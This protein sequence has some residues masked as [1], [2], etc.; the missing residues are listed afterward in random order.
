M[1]QIIENTQHE[2]DAYAR[3]AQENEL[4]RQQNAQLTSNNSQ[5]LIDIINSQ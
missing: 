5:I 1:Q 4:L 3:L 2:R